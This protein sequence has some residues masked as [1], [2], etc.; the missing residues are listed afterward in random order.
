MVQ[1]MG[2][3]KQE[4]KNRFI[5][6]Q[7]EKRQPADLETFFLLPTSIFAGPRPQSQWFPFIFYG[8]V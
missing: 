6:I 4:A 8:N 1:N 7:K 2:G 3:K 5:A